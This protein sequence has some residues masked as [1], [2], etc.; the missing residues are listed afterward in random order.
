MDRCKLVKQKSGCW[1]AVNYLQVKIIYRKMAQ[2][3]RSITVYR[4]KEVREL[5]LRDILPTIS[6]GRGKR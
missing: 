5:Y 1:K 4:E 3:H 6:F 2:E